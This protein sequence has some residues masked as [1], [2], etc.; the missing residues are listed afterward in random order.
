MIAQAFALF[1]SRSTQKATITLSD[2]AD[3]RTARSG[4]RFS[5]AFARRIALATRSYHDGTGLIVSGADRTL[6]LTS[7]MGEFDDL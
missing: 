6:L 5:A 3:L 2:R 1:A 4:R 7:V